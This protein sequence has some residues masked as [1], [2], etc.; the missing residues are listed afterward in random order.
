MLRQEAPCGDG[1][2]GRRW[3]YS[4]AMG[5]VWITFAT[6][7]NLDGDI[8]Y[9]AQEISRCGWKT[10]MHPMF[11]NEDEKIDRLMPAFLSKPEQSDAWIFY[12]SPKALAGQRAERIKAALGRGL[13]ARS[14]FPA[15]ALLT[16]PGV[17]TLPVSHRVLVDDPEWR[18]R[19][20][21]ALQCDLGPGPRP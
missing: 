21:E 13:Q 16:E 9:L 17:E 7:D 3:L 20:G 6:E 19:L 4:G 14:S 1:Y 12:A 5:T 2:I 15:I 11:P 18:Q 8:D 10:R